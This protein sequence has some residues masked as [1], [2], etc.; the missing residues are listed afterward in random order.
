MSTNSYGYGGW[1]SGE[2][3]GIYATNPTAA[4]GLAGWFTG[5][6]YTSLDVGGL[7]KSFIIDYP[8]DPENK[9]L[10]HT[11]V[12]SPEYLCLYRGKVKLNSS[13]DAK[14]S[15]PVYFKDL[16]K[17]EGATIQITCIG[18][19][20]N[21]GYEWNEDF[22]AFIVYGEANKEI[23]WMVLSDRNDPAINLHRKPVVIEKNG[24]D[25]IGYKKGY[26]LHPEAY[27]QPK[28]KGYDYLWHYKNKKIKREV[29]KTTIR[30]ERQVD[31]PD[32]KIEENKKKRRKNLKI[33]E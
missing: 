25:K 1:F 29:K 24:D 7:T 23:S 22:S 32:I 28:E 17:E 31:K 6:T 13:G 4:N 10:R 5:N 16:T 3:R 9:V 26:Y 2:W 18:Q 27:N 12:E 14:V 21:V 30:Q 20:F 8:G 19:P 11:A 33:I 15:L